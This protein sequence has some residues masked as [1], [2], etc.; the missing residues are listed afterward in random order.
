LG[1]RFFLRNQTAGLESLQRAQVGFGN[2]KAAGDG[3]FK[4]MN[5]QP[6]AMTFSRFF[7]P[8]AMLPGLLSADAVLTANFFIRLLSLPGAS[9]TIEKTKV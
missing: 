4:K 5:M 3:R 8:S 2:L 1:L 9:Q 6:A 7:L